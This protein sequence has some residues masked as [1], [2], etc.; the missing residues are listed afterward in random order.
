MSN[1]ITVLPVLSSWGS[2]QGQIR[3]FCLNRI[4]NFNQIQIWFRTKQGSLIG[5]RFR[6]LKEE[7]ISIKHFNLLTFFGLQFQ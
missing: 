3:I 1:I 5:Y 4:R 2:V 6:N 7:K